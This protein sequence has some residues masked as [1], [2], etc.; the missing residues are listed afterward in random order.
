[1]QGAKSEGPR[2]ERRKN[3]RNIVVLVI[4]RKK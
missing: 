2:A 4:L 3:A 1:M